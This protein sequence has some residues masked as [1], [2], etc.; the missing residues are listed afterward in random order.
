MAAR[1]QPRVAYR[2]NL[3]ALSYLFAQT[4][5]SSGT[6][7]DI[8]VCQTVAT[9][10]LVRTPRCASNGGFHRE[11]LDSVHSRTLRSLQLLRIRIYIYFF[12]LRYQRGCST[13]APFSFTL[14]SLVERPANLFAARVWGSSKTKERDS[15]ARVPLAI[16]L[17]LEQSTRSFDVD[18]PRIRKVGER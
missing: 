2:R 8:V 13:R 10:A 4:V 3:F 7:R 16:S 9:C 1:R 5:S 15:T 12:I 18:R 14:F 6:L 11:I 17:T